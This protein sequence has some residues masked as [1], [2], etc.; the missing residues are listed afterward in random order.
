M[1]YDPVIGQPMEKHKSPTSP[2]AEVVV[3]CG[4]AGKCCASRITLHKQGFE[5]ILLCI[6]TF[7]M[8]LLMMFMAEEARL[9]NLKTSTPPAAKSL[10]SDDTW[11][12]AFAMV[13]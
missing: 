1:E 6:V 7:M 3:T 11:K 9:D 2:G 5:V 8:F 12:Y 10:S 13:N 4:D